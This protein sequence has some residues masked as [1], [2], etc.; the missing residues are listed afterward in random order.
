MP[1]LIAPVCECCFRLWQ[2]GSSA[3]LGCREQSH[4]QVAA[5]DEGFVQGGEKAQAPLRA[6]IE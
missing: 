5:S 2:G 6:A 3:F 4:P 1:N